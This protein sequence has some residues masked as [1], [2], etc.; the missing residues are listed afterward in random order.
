[1]RDV[2][3]HLRR[4]CQAA[5]I[6]SDLETQVARFLQRAAVSC[7]PASAMPPPPVPPPKAA[8]AA[9]SPAPAASPAQAA[10]EEVMLQEVMSEEVLEEVP[11]VGLAASPVEAAAATRTLAPCPAAAS[12]SSVGCTGRRGGGRRA[13]SARRPPTP[14]S[15]PRPSAVAAAGAAQA[16]REIAGEKS[17]SAVEVGG[18]DEADGEVM[19]VEER[20]LPPGSSQSKVFA[21]VASSPPPTQRSRGRP[22][23][24]GRMSGASVAGLSEARPLPAVTPRSEG[25]SSVGTAAGFLEAAGEDEPEEHPP[26]EEVDTRS[27]FQ[28]SPL[29]A[30][31]A[32]AGPLSVASSKIARLAMSVASSRASV[33][34]LSEARPLPAA[35]PATASRAGSAS[36]VRGRGAS[37]AASSSSA[38]ARVPAMVSAA[39]SPPPAAASRRQQPDSTGSRSTKWR[40]LDP[41]GSSPWSSGL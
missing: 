21:S 27:V 14:S 41:K 2:V 19:E 37:C 20:S 25:R 28:G 34:G 6:D 39:S 30:R 12:A 8:R 22:Q 7:T 15:G 32:S 10:N 33:G 3:G 23:S 17:A 18:G 35:S 31:Q 9:A 24:S 4:L 16:L 5:G 29:S 11:E 1:M 26:L 36:I 40:R 13:G 38:G